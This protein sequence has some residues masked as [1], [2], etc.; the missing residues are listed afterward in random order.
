MSS[1]AQTKCM[2]QVAGHIKLELAQY[3]EMASFAQFA[4]DLDSSSKQLI[5]RGERLTELLKQP[6]YAP[7][8]VEEQVVSIFIGVHG[9]LDGLPLN[10]VGRFEKY[11]LERIKSEQLGLL[12]EIREKKKLSDDMNKTL[13]DLIA[14]YL[15][16][17]QKE[18]DLT[19]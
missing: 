13:E 2:K 3:R 11:V 7:M 5:S 6:Q 17:F 18:N 12:A 4:S 15:V 14:K 9:F 19:K 1:S 8:S 16:D 10:L